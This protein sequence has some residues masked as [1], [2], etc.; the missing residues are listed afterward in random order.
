MVYIPRDDIL[1]KKIISECYKTL[2]AGYLGIKKTCAHVGERFCWEGMKRNIEDFVKTCDLCQ[3]VADRSSECRNV[4]TIVARHLWEV[5]TIDF[6]YGF[7]PTKGIKHTSVIIITD[8][9]L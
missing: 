6:I 3:R 9:F 1:K 2:L 7:A 4:H 5:M 8:K